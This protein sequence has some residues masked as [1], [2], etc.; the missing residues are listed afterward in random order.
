M[1]LKPTNPLFALLL[2][3][4][5][6][7][8]ASADTVWIDVRSLPEHLIDSIEGDPR[9]SHTEIVAGIQEL[10][11]DTNTEINLYCRSGRRAGVA[12]AAL[13]KAGYHNVNNVGSIEN[14]RQ[15]RNTQEQTAEHSNGSCEQT[16]C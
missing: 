16:N 6:P 8:S 3:L 14:A 10:Y 13:N 15:I 1:S 2:A 4:L 11:P 5:L 12:L 9:I 7:L